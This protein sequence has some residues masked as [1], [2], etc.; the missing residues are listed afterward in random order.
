M[1]AP[2]TAPKQQAE[3]KAF[4]VARSLPGMSFFEIIYRM[5][6]VIA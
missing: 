6:N 1:L 2:L 3:V 4:I 5:H